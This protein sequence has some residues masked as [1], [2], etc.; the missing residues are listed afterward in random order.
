[1]RRRPPP[2]TNPAPSTRVEAEPPSLRELE[3]FSQASLRQWQQAADR[4]SKVQRSLYFDLEPLRQQV[5]QSLLDAIRRGASR[6]LELTAWS[7]IVDWRYT[8]TP[9]SMRGSLRDEG[10]RFNIGERLAPGS[11]TPFPALYLAEDFETAMAEKFSR[12]DPKAVHGL[13]P[14]ALALR[15]PASFT[16]Y[17]IRGR[18]EQILDVTDRDALMPFVD[19]IKTFEIPKQVLTLSRQLGFKKPPWLIRSVG[20]LQKQLLDP[21][22]RL[23]PTQFDLPA[24]SQIFGRIVA[25]AGVHGI[26]YPSS[27][28]ADDKQCLALFPQ[29]WRGSSSFIELVDPAPEGA[30]LIQLDGDS[31]LS[32]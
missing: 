4:L 23:Q 11:F 26:L 30:T 27:R 8:L 3:R 25:A 24:N 14:E 21:Q 22:W 5:A 1:M 31:E 16:Q 29:N 9:L 6:S 13:S 10:G 20:Q 12:P 28:A 15:S 32:S 18:V 2:R 17:R 7:R 19:H